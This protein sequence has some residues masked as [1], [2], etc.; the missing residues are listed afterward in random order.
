[1]IRECVRYWILLLLDKHYGNRSPLDV[2]SIGCEAHLR[3]HASTTTAAVATS[4]TPTTAATAHG[5]APSG[6]FGGGSGCV[7][8]PDLHEKHL[9]CGTRGT[10]V[11]QTLACVPLPLAQRASCPALGVRHGCGTVRMY[12]QTVWLTEAS[13]DRNLTRG[14][15]G[16]GGSRSAIQ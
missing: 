11:R 6:P 3:R 14:L 8:C 12:M 1:M 7:S 5:F 9:I 15:G 4:A 2:R 10:V 16:V 13:R